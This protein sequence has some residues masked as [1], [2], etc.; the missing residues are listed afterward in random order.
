MSETGGVG[1]QA[2]WPELK[3]EI[4]KMKHSKNWWNNK[5]WQRRK[6]TWQWQ[7]ETRHLSRL[8]IMGINQDS[9]GSFTSNTCSNCQ[10]E[11]G[12]KR[13]WPKTKLKYSTLTGC[14]NVKVSS[15]LDSIPPFWKF[16]R[17]LNVSQTFYFVVLCDICA[18]CKPPF[19]KALPAF[20]HQCWW[21]SSG[22]TTSK[23]VTQEWATPQTEVG[24]ALFE[25]L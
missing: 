25:R 5:E 15:H 22:Y 20:N 21:S 10:R 6:V 23:R 18:M 19:V 12:K 2:W 14:W 4:N 11:N 16:L 13:T 3:H 9:C 7:T 17:N 1:D 8:R 24:L